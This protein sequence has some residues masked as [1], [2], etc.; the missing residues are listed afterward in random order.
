MKIEPIQYPLPGEQIIDV[1]PTIQPNVEPF[2][3]RRLNLFTGRSLSSGALN[4]EQQGRSGR[5]ATRG[6]MVSPGVIKGLQVDIEQ[7]GTRSLCRITPGFGITAQGEDVIV[8]QDMRVAISDI[9]V[10]APSSILDS[11][12]S[13]LPQ[14]TDKAKLLA[15]RLGPSLGELLQT[16]VRQKLPPVGILV[17]QPIQAQFL[18]KPSGVLD[19]DQINNYAFADLEV[20]DGCRVVLYTWP[21]E[22]LM[23][24][25]PGAAWR[26]RLAYAIFSAEKGNGLDEVMPWEEI[27]VP[28]GLIAFD[29]NWLPLFID[30][31]AVVRIGGKPKARTPLVNNAGSP[32]LW[33]ARI[34]QFA[35]QL[36]ELD[37]EKIS[38]TELA[39]IFR[40]LPAVG[41]LPK[42]AIDARQGK[43]YFFP[44]AF[45]V[46]ATPIPLE[47]LDL[48]MQASASLTPFDTF[49]D[50]EQVQVLI[51]VPQ[52][53]YDPRLL[54][55]EKVNPQFFQAIDQLIVKRGE[56]LSRRKLVRQ[57][58]AII[59][60]ALNGSPPSYPQPD[61]N[62]LPDEPKSEVP[63][64]SERVLHFVEESGGNRRGLY[65]FENATATLKINSGDILTIYIYIYR[66][67]QEFPWRETHENLEI[68]WRTDQGV[69]KKAGW[70]LNRG[71]HRFDKST[72][73]MGQIIQFNKWMRLEIPA[74]KIGLANT[75]INGMAVGTTYTYTRYN[76]AWGHAGKSVPGSVPEADIVW[77]GE[78]LPTGA[79]IVSSDAW[80]WQKSDKVSTNKTPLFT[81]FNWS[82]Y[83][84]VFRVITQEYEYEKYRRLRP[85]TSQKALVSNI[86]AGKQTYTVKGLKL[87][88]NTYLLTL[89]VCVDPKNAPSKIEVQWKLNENLEPT[90]IYYWSVDDEARSNNAAPLFFEPQMEVWQKIQQVHITVD[91]N[92]VTPSSISFVVYDGRAAFAHVAVSASNNEIFILD[93]QWREGTTLQANSGWNLV[94]LKENFTP[95]GEYLPPLI[96][97]EDYQTEATVATP[98]EKLKDELT[99]GTLNAELTKLS[100]LGLVRFIDYLQEKVQKANDK[101][102]LSFTRVQ[103]DIYRI[104]QLIL[105]ED[106]ANRLVTSPTLAAIA[107]GTQSARV[108]QEQLKAYYDDAKKTVVPKPSSETPPPQ[109]PS[110]PKTAP[111]QTPSSSGTAPSLAANDDKRTNLQLSGVPL[112]A[113]SLINNLSLS[114]AAISKASLP[115][116][117]NQPTQTPRP[118]K[119]LFNPPGSVKPEDVIE[120]SP[121]VG[122]VQR[123][124][125]ISERLQNPAA[126]NAKNYAVV[127]RYEIVNSLLD[128]DINFQKDIPI[129]GIPEDGKPIDPS[130]PPNPPVANI[131]FVKLQE[132]KGS[133]PNKRA[134]I[135]NNLFAGKFDPVETIDT[136]KEADYFAAA[137]KAI[138][139]SVATLRIAEGAVQI[140]RI[141]IASCQNVLNQLQQLA[142]RV[143][144]RLAVIEDE[145]AET[146]HDLSVARLLLEDE[147]KRVKSINERRD[148]II[149]E[150]VPFLIFHRPR[151]TDAIVK[152]PYRALDPG[153]TVSPVPAS[154]NRPIA[155][156][157][158]LRAMV[159]LLREAP[160]QWF[161]RLPRLLDR[162]DRL[163]LLYNTVEGAIA[164]TSRQYSL[165]N[166]LRAIASENNFLGQSINRV[167]IPQEQLIRQRRLELSQINLNAL[168]QQNWR[169]SRNQAEA[170]LSLGDLI[171]GSHNRSDLSREAARE[172][173]NIAHVAASLYANFGEVLPVIR[174]DW[175]QR[176]SQFDESINLQSLASL[177]RW[178]EIPYLERREMQTLVDWLYQQINTRY[179]EGIALISDLIRV[180]ILVASHAP[181]NQ[182]ISGRVIRQVTANQGVL[183]ELAID[184]AKV[185]IG[186]QVVLYSPANQVI[187][188]GLIEDL[189]AGQAAARIVQTFAPNFQLTEN[190]RVQFIS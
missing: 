152:T 51:P 164:R 16:P 68:E 63:F 146:R 18:G 126:I 9:P 181:V 142:G 119:I 111:S 180:C 174:L 88:Q 40:Y 43:D 117:R 125:S 59:F 161:S 102:D 158:E 26:N 138:D 33:Q 89:F 73:Y 167:Y 156:P 34:Q 115:I 166:N 36:A 93:N 29:S 136:E 135:L 157:S 187:A 188:K 147:K 105:D 72:K 124:T 1:I 74:D 179:S 107:K 130:K 168:M 97:E 58:G 48:V 56:W 79:K 149:K 99:Q 30:N 163:E 67:V 10:Y 131:T 129:P 122:Q 140:Y 92:G 69:W 169:Q 170:I 53:W 62:S 94:D 118:G 65:R 2:W 155:V 128:L 23:L 55:V 44:T 87:P 171:D 183:V 11:A 109:T 121:I 178:G 114:P 52:N 80:N 185:R 91:S 81:L 27:G 77:V 173:E 45:A 57:R 95:F 15:R 141:A 7:I 37:L 6:Q 153:V 165:Q 47:Q 139:N 123:T 175:A 90:K 176:L 3:Y 31:Y 113:N 25:T 78:Q 66:E 133:D 148:L 101:I 32:F 154:L 162:L 35:E 127:S 104:R 145:L 21:S 112:I 100:E 42:T 13:N 76:F 5:L 12:N 190:T 189:T 186:M 106:T 137:V 61:P 172:L 82:S 71:F 103:T 98:L 151:F 20:V 24:P 70:S 75:T 64:S 4:A 86:G 22:W 39:K 182:I 83:N 14:D 60:Q 38:I 8:L 46:E 143:N 85:F 160:V 49:A 54:T 184:S 19:Q 116:T 108:T 120:Q 134:E 28:I 150:H 132:L 96:T 110:P 50:Y 144:Q 159:A 41:M 84:P 17:L 177:P